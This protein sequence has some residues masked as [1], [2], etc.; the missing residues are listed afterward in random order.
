MFCKV[1]AQKVDIVDAMLR[2]EGTITRMVKARYGCGFAEYRQKMIGT[3]RALLASK[4]LE[5][6]LSGNVTMLIWLG[7]QWLGQS[8]TPSMTD[9]GKTTSVILTLASEPSPATTTSTAEATDRD[10]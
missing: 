3:G 4:Q 10:E 5:V 8:D 7:K 1:G 9:T 6:A 2:D